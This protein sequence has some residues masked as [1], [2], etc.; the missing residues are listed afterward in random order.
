VDPA[1]IGNAARQDA[2]QPARRVADR[3]VGDVELARDADLADEPG[4]SLRSAVS[5][6]APSL[7]HSSASRT[8]RQG[9][10]GQRQGR[11]AGGGEVVD[12]GEVADARAEATRDLRVASREPVSTTTA[13]STQGSALARQRFEAALRRERS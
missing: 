2:R 5:D 11:V 3:A 12:P 8:R 7:I 10:V 1:L 13:S 9:G 4:A 6:S